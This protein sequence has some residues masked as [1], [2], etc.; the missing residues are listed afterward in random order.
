M[1][2][3]ELSH[4]CKRFGSQS[5]LRDLSLRV[6]EHTI[7]GFIGENG[8][9]KTTSMK[10]ILG[11][12]AADGGEI[13]VC[14]E[15]VRY[16]QTKTNR[17][18]GYLPDVPEFYGY[19][20]PKE[21]LRLCGQIAGV[22][23]GELKRR[24]GELLSLVGLDTAANRRIGGFSRGMKQ[25]LGIAQALIH[26]PKLLICDEPTSALDPAGRKEIIDILNEIKRETTVLFSTHILPDIERVCDEIGLLHGGVM[27]LEGR[28]EEIRALHAQSGFSIEFADAADCSR[29]LPVLPGAERDASARLIY[30]KGA[31]ADM[32]RAMAKLAEQDVCPVSVSLC[33][34]S[35]ESLFLEAAKS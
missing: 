10:L 30:P 12:L 2:V 31:Q 29:F 5:V 16:G 23:D 27:A 20:T 33:E 6:P 24:S 22:P 19:L 35:L 1:D 28:L 7:Y 25:R 26:R 18:V 3:L 32:L 4:V 21:Y 13:R 17:N 8:A 9:G 14:G 15:P 11:L 34:P